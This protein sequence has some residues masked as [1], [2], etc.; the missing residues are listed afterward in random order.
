MA[1]AWAI[2]YL[3]IRFVFRWSPRGAKLYPLGFILRSEKTIG[4][5]DKIASA[6]PSILKILSDMGIA[7]GFGMM[8]FS[9]YI[10]SKNLGTYLFA[11]AAVGPQNIVIPLVIGVTIR[12]EHLPYLLFALGVVLITHEGMH[13]LISRLEKIKIKSTGLFLFYIF[14]GGFVEP[15]E[16]EF[17]KARS[18]AK[19]RVA[20]GGSLANLIVGIAVLLLMIGLFLP[21]A[22]VVV[23]EANGESGIKVNDII[24]SV[25]NVTVNRATLFQNISASN[26]LQ[27]QTSRGTFTYSLKKA[28]NM[29]LAWI[30]RE[31]G[32]KRIDYYFP[33]KISLGS[34]IAEY[35]L[36]RI[37]SWTQFL[38]INVAIFNMMPIYFLDGALLVNALLEPK[39]KSERK[40]KILNAA[41]TSI[42]LF[43]IVSNIAFTFKTFG[44]L[45]I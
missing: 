20:A 34:P 29:P 42:C 21:E 23:L 9:I 44:F 36:Y 41:L 12:F 39:V 37:L 25:N 38:A 30:L 17:Q 19:A 7:L 40:L 3:V 33:A 24:Y 18:R 43:L 4:I 35:I 45:Q 13:G 10:L 16:E 28:I 14:P 11:S 1:I 32:V 6:M 27:V 8:A 22:G 15:D 5:F 2:F 26:T 31:L